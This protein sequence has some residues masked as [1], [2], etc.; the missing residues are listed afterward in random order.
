MKLGLLE[1]GSCKEKS[2]FSFFIIEK[3]TAEVKSKEY[4]SHDTSSV[5]PDKKE[6]H[7]IWLFVNGKVS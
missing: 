3:K 1:I 7:S 2:M 4:I 5:N 6:S